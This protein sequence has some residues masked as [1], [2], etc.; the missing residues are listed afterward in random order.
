MARR[1][2]NSLSLR[3]HF[4][5][6][7]DMTWAN[8]IFRT[9]PTLRKENWIFPYFLSVWSGNI[10]CRARRLVLRCSLCF[11]FDPI[12]AQNRP[13]QLKPARSKKF[14]N[15]FWNCLPK[16]GGNWIRLPH[17]NASHLLPVFSPLFCCSRFFFHRHIGKLKLESSK[18]C[19]RLHVFW[20][21]SGSGASRKLSALL[22][23][24]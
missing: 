18:L 19:Y 17:A 14:Y 15:S 13:H 2:M 8:Y 1:K 24:E 9:I 5:S 11:F 6:S 10:K 12:H 16:K 22:M 23:N 7:N 4:L 3:P 21:L 20:L